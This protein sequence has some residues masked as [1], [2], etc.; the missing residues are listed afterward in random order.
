MTKNTFR[1]IVISVIIL[2]VAIIGICIYNSV[3]VTIKTGEVGYR[4]DRTVKLGDERALPGTSVINKP[5]TG[6][7]YINP[8]T[9]DILIYP[10]TVIAKNWTCIEEDDNKEDMSMQVAS[11][12]GK[13]INADIYI[14]VKAKDF[15]KIITTFGTKKFDNIVNDDIYGLVKGKLSIVTQSYSVYDIQASRSEI[16]EKTVTLLQS[17]LEDVY[18]IELVRFEIGTLNLPAD[19][20]AKIDQKTE[21]M[22]AVELAKLD[23]QKQDEINQK[24]VDQQKAESEKE[25]VRRQNEAD[26]AAYEKEKASQAQLL[27]A[28]NEVK[29]AAQQV[30]AAK[31]QKQAELEKQGA[32]TN[33]Y[34]RD[35]ELDVQMKAVEKINSSVKTIVTNSD[36]SGWAALAGLSPIL[37]AINN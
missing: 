36:G 19:I 20:Q 16:Q 37:E 27:V 28:E 2:V 3:A 10:T 13:N 21:A 4:Y 14:S 7:A 29:I 9:Q 15:G 23:R 12:E 22:N 31:L 35:K 25:L 33:E 18:G 11:Q 17:I 1:A 5:L 6:R 32:Y 8:F 24:I 34:F 30:E 26:A